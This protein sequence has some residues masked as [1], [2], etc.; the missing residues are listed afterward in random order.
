MS[1]RQDVIFNIEHIGDIIEEMSPLA[2]LHH[3]EVNIFYE[4]PLNIN[5]GQYSRMRD[6]YTLATCRVNGQLCGWVGYFVYDHL[7]HIGYKIAK[8]D[9]YYVKPECRN[10]GIGTKLFEYAESVLRKK[11]VKRV[12][13][14][15]K[16]D[17]DHTKMIERMGY[18]NHEKNFTKVLA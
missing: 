7:R 17:H 4:T 14:S 16:V 15:C 18:Q 11:G 8:E 1:D 6:M 10:I 2:V 3:A 5:W 9:W 13:M 12:M